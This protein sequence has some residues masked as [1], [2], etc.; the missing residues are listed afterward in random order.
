MNVLGENL[1]PTTDCEA[2]KMSAY[3]SD[4][5]C[6]L[7][8]DPSRLQIAQKYYIKIFHSNVAAAVAARHFEISKLDPKAG[9]E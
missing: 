1:A 9:R 3:D 6:L 8:R 4:D 2:R 5:G 7:F